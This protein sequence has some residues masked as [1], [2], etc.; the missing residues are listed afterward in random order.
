MKIVLVQPLCASVLYCCVERFAQAHHIFIYTAADSTQLF[1]S[2][3]AEASQLLTLLIT[4]PCNNLYVCQ[5]HTYSQVTC[6][7][8]VLLMNFYQTGKIKL[9]LCRQLQPLTGALWL[10]DLGLLQSVA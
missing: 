8:H 6:L 3:Q 7:R 2:E 4:E 1:V 10:L 5:V 9:L